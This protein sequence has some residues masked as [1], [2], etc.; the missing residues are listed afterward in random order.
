MCEVLPGRPADRKHTLT[1]QQHGKSA[2]GLTILL[3]FKEKKKIT[4]QNHDSTNQVSDAEIE[5]KQGWSNC[6]MCN[7]VN[8]PGKL[9]YRKAGFAY[10]H[11]DE[12]F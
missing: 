8:H 3:Y 7:H 1:A 12:S 5:R 11:S 2:A 4:A 6:T 10:T 9:S